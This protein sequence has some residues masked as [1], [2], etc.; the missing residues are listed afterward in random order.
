[1][2]DPYTIILK[3]ILTEKSLNLAKQNK[4]VF[5]VDRNAN[6]IEIGKAV[7]EIFKVKVKSV[8]VINEK[9]KK[10]RLGISQG[11]TSTKKKAIV[12]LEPGHKIELIS[13]V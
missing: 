6:K 1:M 11:F 9:P 8:A 5:E 2:R 4:Y 7:E 10:R 12:T 3:P 13:G